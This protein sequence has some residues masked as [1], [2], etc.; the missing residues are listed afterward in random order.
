M[1]AP[2]IVVPGATAALCRRTNFRKRFLAPWHEDVMG[3]WPYSLALAQQKTNVAIHQTIL[4][5]EHHHTEVTSTEANLPNFKRILHGESSK[6]L[7]AL[8]ARERH[9]RPP[10]G[11]G[12]P[13]HPRRPRGG[14]GRGFGK[15]SVSRRGA[16]PSV[17]PWSARGRVFSR[18]AVAP[19]AETAAA[20]GGGAS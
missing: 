15:R 10:S 4:V 3:I 18:V 16:R 1:T 7:N 2:S 9:D 20:H 14:G 6:A 5:L 11:L 8:M 17:H 19:R 13:R 12:R